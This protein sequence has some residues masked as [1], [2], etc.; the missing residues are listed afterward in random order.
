MG[1]T[2]CVFYHGSDFRRRCHT[3]R[4]PRH[5]GNSSSLLFAQT[6]SIGSG[7]I[8]TGGTNLRSRRVNTPS[9]P[10]NLNNSIWKSKV[11]KIRRKQGSWENK[12]A[13]MHAGTENESKFSFLANSD[14]EVE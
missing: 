3:R 4:S 5:A 7:F 10:I 11:R 12:Y 14:D 1:V 6:R 13:N 2:W 8:S 9:M